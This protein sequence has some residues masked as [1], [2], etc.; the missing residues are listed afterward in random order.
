M[1][2]F[3]S[4]TPTISQVYQYTYKNRH[5]YSRFFNEE[6]DV[7]KTKIKI[8]KRTVYKKNKENKWMTP[9]E[10]LYVRSESFPQYGKYLSVKTKGAK[11]QRKI[12][13][14]YDIILL[15]QNT[16][17]GY[18]FWN[19]KI[20]WHVGSFKKY[21]KYIPQNKV[22]QIHG[23]TRARLEKKYGKLPQKKKNEMI[24]RDIESIRKRSKYIS[25]GDYVSRE[26][27]INGDYYFRVAPLQ[28]NFAC[29]YGKVWY[30][31]KPR[32]ILFPFFDKHMLGCIHALMRI[33]IIKYK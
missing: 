26:L 18:D 22:A 9:E 12:R 11:K 2:E 20:C 13:H 1:I 6:R 29:G 5:T 7:L 3:K 21:P 8:E 25:D 19:S 17:N 27:G 32:D 4:N 33:G 14:Q 10:R 31:E 28:L 24:R 15:I 16:P 30:T 23:D